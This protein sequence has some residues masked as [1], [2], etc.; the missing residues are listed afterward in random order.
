MESPGV[1]ASL[2]AELTNTPLDAASSARQGEVAFRRLLRMII[3]L[4]CPPGALLSEREVMDSLGIS[5][6]VLRQAVTH[7]SGLGLLRTLPRKGLMVAP[8]D[9]L[10]VST[11][12]DA[13]WAIETRLARFASMRATSKDIEVLRTHTHAPTDLDAADQNSALLG[14]D[15]ALH[16]AVARM[17]HNV[18]LEDALT[19]ILPANVRLWQWVYSR[20][21]PDRQ[22]TFSHANIVAAIAAGDP[23]A[24]EA[25]VE[26]HLRSSR[27]FLAEVLTSR[28][29]GDLAL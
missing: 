5:R 19:R 3:T 14:R 18:F 9:A 26:D 21:G 22:V 4:A 20:V 17:A 10:D 28:I 13:R 29:E 15:Q 1:L 23:D 6:P 7:L 27:R 8:I 24:A 2:R 16:L 11:V 25:A 12:Y